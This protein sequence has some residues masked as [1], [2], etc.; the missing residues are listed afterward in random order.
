MNNL[1]LAVLGLSF[2]VL[3][4]AA[5]AKVFEL[6]DAKPAITVN[7]P[8]AWSPEEIEKGAQA[9]SPDTSIYVALE[10]EKAKD[11]AKA[12]ADTIIWLRKKGVKID[13]SS[14]RRNQGEINGLPVVNIEFDGKDEDGPTS[15]ALSVIDLPGDRIGILTFWGSPDGQKKYAGQLAG[16]LKSLQP[17]NP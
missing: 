8:D 2:I 10:I 3:P 11:T 6:P 16:I 1:R 17:L 15:V 5:R 4:V 9:T 7:F 13:Q 12:V 14:Q